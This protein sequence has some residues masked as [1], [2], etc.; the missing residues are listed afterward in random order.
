LLGNELAILVISSLWQGR[1]DFV[2]YELQSVFRTFVELVHLSFLPFLMPP[3]RRLR[4]AVLSEQRFALRTFG[5]RSH[6]KAAA[7]LLKPPKRACLLPDATAG[8]AT[9]QVHCL[10]LNEIVKR[11]FRPKIDHQLLPPCLL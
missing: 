4:R 3:L 8:S 7:A 6:P 5:T 10:R 11:R 9:E 2:Q 1:A